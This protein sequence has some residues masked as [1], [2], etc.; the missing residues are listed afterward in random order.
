MI[1]KTKLKT[2]WTKIAECFNNY[3]SS[4]VEKLQQNLTFGKNKFSK[5]LN[6][7]L[8]HNFP[9]QSVDTKKLF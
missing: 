1:L 3:F 4:I 8:K 9:F 7:P 6:K 5:Y 2:D